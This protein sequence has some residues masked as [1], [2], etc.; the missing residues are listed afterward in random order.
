MCVRAC[1]R[2]CVCVCATAHVERSEDNPQVAVLPFHYEFKG[3]NSDGKAS[4]VNTFTSWVIS[5][6]LFKSVLENSDSAQGRHS[7]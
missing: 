1:T 6:A 5:P 2:V 4:G 7:F 3:S